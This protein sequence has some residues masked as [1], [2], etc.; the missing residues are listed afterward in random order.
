ME[1]TLSSDPAALAVRGY[2]RPMAMTEDGNAGPGSESAIESI[3]QAYLALSPLMREVSEKKFRIPPADAE[4]LVNTVFEVYL[5]R[6]TTVRDLER[7]LIASVCNASRDYWRARKNIEPLPDDVGELIEGATAD[8]E[9]RL[10]RSLTISVALT[11]L[12]RKCCDALYLH[13]LGGYSAV[14][15]A[16]KLD[17]TEQ[18]VWRLLS[19]CRTRARKMLGG[20]MGKKA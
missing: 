19:T 17:T 1:L 12:G 7:Y 10:V 11:R 15:I 14:E 18:Y 9:E 4:A 2:T 20:L 6:R 8:A 5:R 13:H 3:E 16:E